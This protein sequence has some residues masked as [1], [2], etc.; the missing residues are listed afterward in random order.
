MFADEDKM[1]RTLCGRKPI[2]RLAN[3]LP[4]V[5]AGRRAADLHAAGS[6][7]GGCESRP[8]SRRSRDWPR[9]RWSRSACIACRVSLVVSSAAYGA[10]YGLLPIGW[11]VFTAILLYRLTIETGKFEIIKD[12]IGSLTGDRALAGA[13][14]R[15]RVRRVHRRR[16]GIRNAGGG[17]GGDADRAG[18]LAVLRGGDLPA[19]EHV[20]GGVRVDRHAAGGVAGVTRLADGSRSRRMS[21]GSARRFRCSCRRTW[22]W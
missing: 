15:V 21:G 5:R 22:C 13:A 14:D 8:G 16:G 4:S 3:S 19:G 20:A 17:S 12:S 6:A 7:G 11:I 18:I 10:A 9:R 1:V 2:L